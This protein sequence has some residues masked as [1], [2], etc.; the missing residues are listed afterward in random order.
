MARPHYTEARKALICPGS[1]C[2][3]DKR[4][5]AVAYISPAQPSGTRH[6]LTFYGRRHQPSDSVFLTKMRDIERRIARHFHWRQ[7]GA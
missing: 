1:V 4:S 2:I 3:R 7:R 5:D 6:I